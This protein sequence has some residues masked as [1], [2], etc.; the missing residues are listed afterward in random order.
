MEMYLYAILVANFVPPKR[1]FF[2][3]YLILIC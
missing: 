3:S 1:G 2:F